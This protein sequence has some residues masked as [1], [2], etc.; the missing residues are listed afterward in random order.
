LI[1]CF[2]NSEYY[3]SFEVPTLLRLLKGIDRLPRGATGALVFASKDA[4][5]GT[6]LV[7]ENR[8]CWA[9]AS[10]MEHRLTDILRHETDPPLPKA[11]FE[12]VY[13]ECHRERIPLGETLVERGIVTTEGLS[14]A[15]RRHTAEAICVLASSKALSPVWASNRQRP[16]DAQHT[17]STGELMSCV[18]S[19]GFDKEAKRAAQMLQEVTPRASVGVA[20]LEKGHELPVAQISVDGWECAALVELGHWA[21]KA[22]TAAE[23]ENVV[24]DELRR[25]WRD[26]PLVYVSHSNHE[27]ERRLPEPVLV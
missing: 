1:L 9:A 10:N 11:I 15:L 22:L 6:V 20:Y 18:G 8:V 13:E 14:H 16:Y 24:E 5:Q 27:M 4:P 12:S 23:T 7:E 26:G 2:L 25:A 19:F 3:Q 21:R 17:F